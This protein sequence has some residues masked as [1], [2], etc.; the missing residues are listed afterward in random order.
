MSI[1]LENLTKRI[2]AQRVLDHVSLELHGGELFV[3]L[4]PSGSGKTTILRLIAGLEFPDEG[5]IILSGRDVTALPAQKR[6]VG[7]VFQNYSVF[8][9]MTA[10]QN[11]EFGLKIRGVKRAERIAKRDQLLEVVGLSGLGDRR[12]H[13]L[14]GGQLQRV[15][16]ARALAYNPEILLLDEPFGALD[17]K[18][19]SQL[20]RTLKDIQRELS[21]TTLLVTHDQEEAL[22]LADG[23]AVLDR[24]RLL[25]QGSPEELYRRPRS[26]FVATFLGGGTVIAGRARESEG[27]FGTFAVPIPAGTPHEEG[28]RVRL[29]FRPEEVELAADP[30]DLGGPVL[31]EAT[32]LEDSFL[33]GS[34][35]LRL[36]LPMKPPARQIAPAVPFGEEGLIVEAAAP[37][38]WTHPKESLWTGLRSWRFLDPPPPRILAVDSGAEASRTLAAGADLADALDASLTI[39]SIPGRPEEAET[40]RKALA[41]G[42]SSLGWKDADIRVRNGSVASE[43]IAE[44][45]ESIYDLLVTDL[46]EE[47]DG[48]ASASR[49]YLRRL[50]AG[51]STPLLFLRGPWKHPKNLLI[52]TAVGEPGKGNVRLGGWLARWLG[53]AVVLLHVSREAPTS[54]LPLAHL[55]RGVKS[56]RAIGIPAQSVIRTSDSIPEA[57]LDQAEEMAADLVVLGHHFR[58]S[59]ALFNRDDVT[60]QVALEIRRPILIV[61]ENA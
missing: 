41:E 19:R 39:L 57:V 3:L 10:A 23:I 52:C 53:S 51:T 49:A 25:G 29:L 36:R 30:K 32:V 61:P 4:G 9:H 21:V 35:R 5:R 28:A 22:E 24:G 59:R 13:Q 54:P 14:S 7:F 50:L 43:I 42:A 18:I 20:R 27:N 55:D 40:R 48:V 26:L 8:R 44:Q 12:A 58:K 31:G 46:P 45:A 33:G 56:L 60:W 1:Q 17:A 34:R 37:S 11:I 16:L 38:G 15:A 6:G 47:P 2:G